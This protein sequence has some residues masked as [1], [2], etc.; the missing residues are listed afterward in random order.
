MSPVLV[1][2]TPGTCLGQPIDRQRSGVLHQEVEAYCELL[3][4]SQNELPFEEP[5]IG[6]Q[7]WLRVDR[8]EPHFD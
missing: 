8:F 5:E 2:A 7:S 6:L 1:E 3:S 4:G